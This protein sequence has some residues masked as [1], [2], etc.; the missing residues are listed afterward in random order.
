[1]YILAIYIQYIIV[2]DYDTY[3]KD[4]AYIKYNNIIVM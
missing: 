4:A 2:V 3:A 1:M